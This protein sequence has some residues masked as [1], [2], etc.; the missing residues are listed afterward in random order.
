MSAVQ[1]HPYKPETLDIPQYVPKE[2]QRLEIL[3]FFFCIVAAVVGATWLRAT[4]LHGKV[5]LGD[6]LT[7]VWMV[8]TGLVHSLTE[9]WWVT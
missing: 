5:S 9:G 8:T 1:V 6:R 2:F 4:R 3:S 7:A